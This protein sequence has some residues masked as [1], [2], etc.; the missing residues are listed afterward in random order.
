LRIGLWLIAFGLVRLPAAAAEDA[1]PVRPILVVVPAPAGGAL[2]IAFRAIRPAL[3]VEL[4]MP[5]AI[6]NKAGASGVI[7][8][9]SVA[10]ARPDGYTLAATATS[11]LT[12]VN[13]SAPSVP[14]APGDFIPIGNYALDF[15]ILVV[16]A[17][18]PW[19]SLAE[20]ARYARTHPGQLSY[21]SAGPG[22]LSTLAMESVKAAFGLDIVQV[23]YPGAPQVTNALLGRQLEIGAVPLSSAAPLLRDGSLRAVVTTAPRR[24]A[25][26]PDVPTLAEAGVPRA[27]RALAIGLYAPAGTPPFAIDRLARA[28]RR[29]IGS[30]PVIAGLQEAGLSV[31]YEDGARVGADLAAAYGS[32]NRPGSKRAAAP[33]GSD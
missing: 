8:M 33:S 7:G 6:E 4:G 30:A 9:E 27:M 18:A 20:L 15:T 32:R 5:M 28:L 23:P 25:F 21:G 3:S 16:R 19:R 14:Y 2:D 31:E 22:T 1:Y 24:P 12:L 17:D 10:L 29:T 11:T 13:A 26:F